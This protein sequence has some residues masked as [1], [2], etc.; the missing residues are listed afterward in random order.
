MVEQ[1]RVQ[2]AGSGVEGKA[3][4]EA[5]WGWRGFGAMGTLSPGHPGLAAHLVASTSGE[6]FP[7]EHKA[8]LL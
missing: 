1:A 2:E 8:C 6:P 5:K 7:R 4:N 3:R